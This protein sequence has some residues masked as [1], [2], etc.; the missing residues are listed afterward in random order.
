MINSDNRPIATIVAGANASG[1]T[2]LV[3]T[4]YQNTF[5]DKEEYIS[6]DLIIYRDLGW[7]EE[8]EKEV[9]VKAFALA[10]EQ[11]NRIIGEKKD[12]VIEIFTEPMKERMAR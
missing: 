6:P 10:D 3:S 8:N 7:D 12:F 9:Y 11:R 5:F 1:K 2:T 4:L